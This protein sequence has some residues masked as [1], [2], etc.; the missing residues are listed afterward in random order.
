MHIACL[1]FPCHQT[2]FAGISPFILFF[3]GTKIEISDIQEWSLLE[4]NVIN[5]TSSKGNSGKF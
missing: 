5:N 4:K 1:D 2:N 3:S